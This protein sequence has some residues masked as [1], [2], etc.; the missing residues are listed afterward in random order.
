MY[1]PFDIMQNYFADASVIWK[2][3]FQVHL[4]IR[5]MWQTID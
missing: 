4:S 5:A 3:T 1:L 2:V